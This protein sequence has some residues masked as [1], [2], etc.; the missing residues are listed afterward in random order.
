MTECILVR[1]EVEFLV[2]PDDCAGDEQAA[3][4]WVRARVA[5]SGGRVLL[6]TEVRPDHTG[7]LREC[8]DLI[9]EV[10]FAPADVDVD[11]LLRRLGAALNETEK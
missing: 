8:R 9:R 3:M 4:D 7:L 11:D 10:A 5:R 2:D 1:G 6:R